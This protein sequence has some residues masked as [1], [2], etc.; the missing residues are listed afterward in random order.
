MRRNLLIF[1][2][3]A[4][5]IA[6]AAVAARA[7][8]C[9]TQSVPAKKVAVCKYVGKPGVN[10]VLKS[11]ENPILVSI[12]ALVGPNGAD[13]TLGQSFS[14]AQGRSVVVA[15]AGMPIPAQGSCPQGQ[16]P[17]AVA[18]AQPTITAATCTTGETLTLPV[19]TPSVAYTSTGLLTGPGTVSIT[20]T[21]GDA[22][23]LA[24]AAGWQATADQRSATLTVTLAGAR[25]DGCTTPI[26]A[27]PSDPSITAATC[28]SGETLTVPADTDTIG[29]S[30]TGPLVGPG[31]VTITAEAYAAAVI[32]PADGWQVASDQRSATRTFTL[33]GPLTEGCAASVTVTLTDPVLSAA[34][35]THPQRLTMPASTSSV[36]YSEEGPLT[37]PGAVTIT[38][39]ASEGGVFAPRGA[40]HVTASGDQA[41]LTV[42][43]TGRLTTD[44]S[45]NPQD[46]GKH[47][48]HHHTPPPVTGSPTRRPAHTL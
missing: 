19:D 32:A 27:A 2:T 7:V 46:R 30:T 21:A 8:A 42:H 1:I 36:T 9:D 20:A 18:P 16:G 17:V 23:V 6:L 39:T 22:Y 48:R 34:S 5:V 44:C 28:T 45:T 4:A 15:L 33:A 47:H 24:A 26:T 14:D 43:L 3:T 40:W 29:Y 25:T 11:G 35:C 38:A 12:N 31:A 37:G 41:T 10:E 13:P